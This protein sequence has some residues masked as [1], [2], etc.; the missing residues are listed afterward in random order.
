MPFRAPSR[1]SYRALLAAPPD[2]PGPTPSLAAPGRPR[3]PGPAPAAGPSR[4]RDRNRLQTM[5]D[6]EGRRR[7]DSRRGRRQ[8]EGIRTPT[9]PHTTSAHRAATS[10]RTGPGLSG[11]S[12]N[13]IYPSL[14]VLDLV[15]Q[16]E[17]VWSRPHRVEPLHSHSAHDMIDK[18]SAPGVL[19]Q[20]RVHT[21][22]RAQQPLQRWL[23]AVPPLVEKRTNGRDRRNHRRPD[24]VHH[25]VGMPSSS[26]PARSAG[27]G[28]HA[29]TGPG[30]PS[31]D[32]ECRPHS[33]CRRRG[34]SA[35]SARRATISPVVP[36]PT[37]E[38]NPAN[39]SDMYPASHG[40]AVN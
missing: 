22:Q 1:A 34:S 20:L 2:H 4:P 18:R 26:V 3:N 30:L 31:P 23:T 15:G 13:A 33:G 36:V 27:P 38:I 9:T 6:D 39:A 25:E 12:E 29:V 11:G 32:R 14:R 24:T 37:S 40:F 19:A 10:T 28:P 17:S 16:R 21:D 7:S 8:R 5:V 35:N